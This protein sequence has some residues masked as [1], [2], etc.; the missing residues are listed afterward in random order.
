MS[1]IHDLFM[2]YA[3]YELWQSLNVVNKQSVPGI[4]D[5]MKQKKPCVNNVINTLEMD[6][7]LA[8][9]HSWQLIQML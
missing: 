7:S 3:W 5:I 2:R 9:I 4:Q 6:S 1:P 8:V